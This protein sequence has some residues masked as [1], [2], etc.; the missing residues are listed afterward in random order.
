MERIRRI[1]N[2]PDPDVIIDDSQQWLN[3]IELQH[4]ALK[5]ATGGAID[6]DA[7][8]VWVHQT[9]PPFSVQTAIITVILSVLAW[10]LVFL[11]LHY[12]IF[13]NVVRCP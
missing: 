13:K 8:Q 10:F 4:D 1:F 3:F 11:I 7:F 2:T 12:V 6:M 9:L 5:A